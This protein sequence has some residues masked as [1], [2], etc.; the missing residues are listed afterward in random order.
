MTFDSRVFICIRSTDFRSDDLTNMLP[1]PMSSGQS[2]TTKRLESQAFPLTHLHL[3]DNELLDHDGTLARD[4]AWQV[5]EVMDA[6]TPSQNAL[7]S[8]GKVVPFHLGLECSYGPDFDFTFDVDTLREV[9]AVGASIDFDLYW[10]EDEMVETLPGDFYPCG[11]LQVSGP[12]WEEPFRWDKVEWG[13]LVAPLLRVH[14]EK[15][16]LLT[17]NTKGGYGR[18][19][20]HFSANAVRLLAKSG[21]SLRMIVEPGWPL[22]P[23]ASPVAG[24]AS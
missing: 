10:S 20:A 24:T 13:R 5:R 19:V 6:V 16:Q 12:D 7:A 18:P 23:N 4:V 15:N 21:T 1:A 17:F 8:F 9:S 11:V 3:F 22:L 2:R 14:P